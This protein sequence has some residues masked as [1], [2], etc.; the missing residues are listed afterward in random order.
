MA[1]AIPALYEWGPPF[2]SRIGH[3]AERHGFIILLRAVIRTRRLHAAEI[4][5]S[6]VTPRSS[7]P[8]VKDALQVWTITKYLA[9]LDEMLALGVLFAGDPTL[10]AGQR[11]IVEHEE[12]WILG[13][14]KAGTRSGA[15]E[16][17]V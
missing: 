12:G 4:R 9:A 11:R 5:P 10:D 3:D 6:L 1:G 2:R 15:T 17:A 7:K 16:A 8:L 13:V 14:P